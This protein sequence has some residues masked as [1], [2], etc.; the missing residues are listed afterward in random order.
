[1]VNKSSCPEELF[2]GCR[3][4]DLLSQH[5]AGTG[6]GLFDQYLRLGTGSHG[7]GRSNRA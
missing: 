1:M 4:E 3:H 6:P 2:S 5:L 7:S